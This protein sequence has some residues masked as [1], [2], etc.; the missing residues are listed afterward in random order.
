MQPFQLTAAKVALP[1]VIFASLYGIAKL[2][3]ANP[4]AAEK[5][6]FEGNSALI[7]EALR[8]EPVDYTIQLESYGTVQP[9]TRTN[10]VSQVGGQVRSVHP[11]FRDGGFFNQGDVLIEIDPR[12]YRADVDIARGT[13]MEARQTLLEAQARS[14]QAQ[15]D[16]DAL[17]NDTPASPLVLRQPQLDAAEARVASA[18]AS[19]R[20]AQLSLERTQVTAP[21]DGRVLSQ[22]VDIGQVVN[23]MTVLGD[24]YA[25]D[26]V[27]IRLPLRNR[28][29]QF[30]DLPEAV[31]DQSQ[32]SVAFESDLLEGQRWHGSVVRTEAAIDTAARQLHVVARVDDPFGRDNNAGT[33]MK[34]GQYVTAQITG[35]SL[36]DVL[37][38][39]NANIYQGTFVFVVDNGV[40]DRRRVDIAWQNASESVISAGIEAGEMLVTTQLGQVATGTRVQVSGAAT[41]DR[42]DA[43]AAAP[44]SNGTT[45][46]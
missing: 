41:R 6:E 29:L 12:D 32:A 5:R 25:T 18:E 46:R 42:R 22:D 40:L 11:S 24:I 37:V 28:D 13:L 44:A 10:L 27:E 4:P 19:L 17:G 23:A 15:A 8:L 35:R 3:G 30:I 38:V 39:P 16:W 36:Q 1:V 2:I 14:A 33:P 26:D 43:N 20:K 31:G 9:R 34:I 21:F 7:V 45:S